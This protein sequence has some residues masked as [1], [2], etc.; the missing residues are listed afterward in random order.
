LR[1]QLLEFINE[2]K[3][4]SLIV[5]CGLPGTLKTAIS[6]EISKIKGFQVLQTDT[7]R[8]EVLKGENIFDEKV[9]SNMVKREMVY[10]EMFRRAENLTMNGRG[11]ILDATFV[12][13]KLRRK[14]AEIASKR[15][16]PLIIIQTQCSDDVAIKRILGRGGGGTISNA[17]TEQAYYNN[18]RIFEPVNLDKL[19]RDYPDL[20]VKHVIVDTNHN[21][22]AKLTIIHMDEKE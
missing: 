13:R 20:R 8:R 3:P 2:I 10:N 12:T 19:K 7:I 9:A 6:N 5:M 16:M 1:K 21:D 14:A 18:K 4:G 22:I 15:G 11:I 17:L